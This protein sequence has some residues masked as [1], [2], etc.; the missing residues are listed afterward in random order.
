MGKIKQDA[1]ISKIR[2]DRLNSGRRPPVMVSLGPHLAWSAPPHADPSDPYTTATGVLKRFASEPPKPIPGGLRKFRRFVEKWCRRNLTPLAPDV[3]TSVETW[4]ASTDYPEWRKAELRT[5]WEACLNIRDPTKRY[6]ECKSFAKDETYPTWKHARAINSRS[7][8]FKCAVGPIFK[9]IEKEVF[10]HDAFIKKIPV[11]DRPQYIIDKL[12]RDGH[13]Y[14]ATDYTSFEALFT[15]EVMESC[16]MVLY[17]YMTR[18]IPGGDEFMELVRDALLGVNVCSFKE[19][20]TQV[21]GCRMSGEMCTSLGNSFTNLMLM[22]YVCHKKGCRDVAIVVEGD[23]GL[24]SM[25]GRFLPTAKDFADLG[26]IIKLEEHDSL[27]TASFCGLV[28]VE[29][30]MINVVDPLK[31]LNNFG[32]TTARYA[33]CGDGIKRDL[34]RCKALSLAHQYP[35]CPIISSLAQYGLRATRGRDIRSFVERTR[36]LPQW[37]REKLLSAMSGDLT[38]L[39]VPP[40][41]RL[42]VESLYGISVETQL[43]MEKELDE[44]DDLSPVCSTSII[45]VVPKEWIQYHEAY[46]V[47]V[48][49]TDMDYPSSSWDSAVCA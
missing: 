13:K 9:L 42:L 31:V 34:L 17:E 24:C 48:F 43:Q 33:R 8:E 46:V 38:P 20:T 27:T 7:D 44:K 1:S 23:D 10:K 36:H 11:R 21:R 30:D 29:E 41:T 12:K 39:P 26:F 45:H 28:F 32:W 16:E 2:E 6:M 22:L 3:D 25:Q 15:P 35:G 37:E 4:L 47:N 40:A 19:F 18:L 5:K 49:K 14:I